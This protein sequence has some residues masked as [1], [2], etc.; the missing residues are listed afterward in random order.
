MEGFLLE[1]VSIYFF[2]SFER[3]TLEIMLFNSTY[4]Q[5]KKT[6]VPRHQGMWSSLH[7]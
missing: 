3:L 2:L 5:K 7:I 1:A 4:L 6:G